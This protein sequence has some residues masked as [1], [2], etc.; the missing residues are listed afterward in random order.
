[1]QQTNSS[2]SKAQNV[3]SIGAKR[4][5]KEESLTHCRALKLTKVGSGILKL[6]LQ[7]NCLSSLKLQQDKKRK[8]TFLA[9]EKA[10]HPPCSSI[11]EGT[12]VNF[13]NLINVES[14]TSRKAEEVGLI[15]PPPQP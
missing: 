15:M 11:K 5:L 1:M 12:H 14:L 4:K 7:L 9:R 8:I 3:V 10:R 6:E 13:R 2:P